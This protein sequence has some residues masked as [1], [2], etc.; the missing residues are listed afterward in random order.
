MS[1]R[2]EKK[3]GVMANGTTCRRVDSKRG[4]EAAAAAQPPRSSPA[5]GSWS[6]LQQRNTTAGVR[7]TSSAS[8]L[9]PACQHTCKHAAPTCASAPGT[10]RFSI[11]PSMPATFCRWATP[12]GA[13]TE[14]GAHQAAWALLREGSCPCPKSPTR[15][16]P[17]PPARLRPPATRVGAPPPQPQACATHPHGVGILCE[18]N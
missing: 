3:S 10:P 7:A 6:L 16:S 1:L 5:S 13:T 14:M 15:P 11:S 18:V 4:R 2:R 9:L 17:R 8:C 12:A